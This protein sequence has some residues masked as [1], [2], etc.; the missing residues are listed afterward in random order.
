MIL[1]SNI[2]FYEEKHVILLTFM[3]FHG[4][5]VFSYYIT[6]NYFCVS[7]ETWYMAPPPLPRRLPHP[8][9]R[10]I[11]LPQRL[12]HPPGRPRLQP[13]RLQH[14]PRRLPYP[15]RRLPYPPRRLQLHQWV[16]QPK[17]LTL[18]R[19]QRGP[20]RLQWQATLQPCLRPIVR[21]G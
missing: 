5:L 13:G 19:Q 8:P 20:V 12:P 18:V 11:H 9:R 17:G 14:P 10:P 16:R 3:L 6:I 2:S 1:K 21:S 7:K 4:W 15:P